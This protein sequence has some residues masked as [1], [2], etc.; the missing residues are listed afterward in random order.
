MGLY[1]SSGHCWH[2][3]DPLTPNVDSPGGH[4]IHSIDS[5]EFEN[6]FCGHN[7]HPIEPK[8]LLKNPRAQGR[9]SVAPKISLKV[10]GVHKWHVLSIS[11]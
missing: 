8:L 6:V 3:I 9:H 2:D 4:K 11:K 7:I 10:P 1:V 5:V